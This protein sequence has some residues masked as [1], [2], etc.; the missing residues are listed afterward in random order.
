MSCPN[1][2]ATKL[3][4]KKDHECKENCEFNHSYNPNSSCVLTNKGDYL[5]IKTDGKNNVNYNGQNLTLANVR[6]YTPSLHTFDGKHIDGEMILTHHGN[7]LNLI[8]SVPVTAKSGAGDSISFFSKIAPYI[9]TEKNENATINVS[10]WSLNNVMPAA[11][12]PFYHY[13]GSSPYPPCHMK[14]TLVVFD[15]DYA[16]AIKPSDLSTIKK[17]I[18][19]SNSANTNKEGFVGGM[20]GGSFKEGLVTY[21]SSGA[22]NTSEESGEAMVCT[23]YYD[24]D[25]TSS[26]TVE[27][28][29]GGE[30]M[31]IK[32]PTVDL[33]KITQSP[34]F[35]GGIILLVLVIGF[36]FIKWGLPK[37][38]AKLNK[39]GEVMAAPEAELEIPST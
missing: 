14:A 36:I 3:E 32:K 33:S 38:L 28:G 6:F 9:P 4:S 17:V 30:D 2:E 39:S 19:S 12:T 18:K 21:N 8:V 16:V 25:P 29:S 24:T 1:N 27:G 15:P 7:G 31:N 10:N 22:N 34:Y 26:T 35:I 5:E 11:K 13:K 23:E 37:I 20:V